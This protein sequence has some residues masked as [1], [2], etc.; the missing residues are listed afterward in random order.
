[1][2]QEQI[3]IPSA[4][5]AFL[6]GNCFSLSMLP[7]F[8]RVVLKLKQKARQICTECLYREGPAPPWSA[9]CRILLDLV[10]TEHCGN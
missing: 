9:G 6:R 4:T 10:G 2:E 7:R 1:M 5:L 8:I 3:Y